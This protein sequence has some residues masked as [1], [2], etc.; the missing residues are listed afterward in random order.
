MVIAL[1]NYVS[2]QHTTVQWIFEVFEDLTH[3]HETL[4]SIFYIT[5]RLQTNAIRKN[6]VPRK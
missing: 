6:I 3:K 5:K 4:V 2:V 1:Y